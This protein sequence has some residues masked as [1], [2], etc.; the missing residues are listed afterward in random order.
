MDG[1]STKKHLWMVLAPCTEV[2]THCKSG[3]FVDFG[4]RIIKKYPPFVSCNK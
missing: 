2:L 1:L 3:F 4:Y